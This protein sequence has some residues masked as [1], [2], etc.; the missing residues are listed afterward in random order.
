[1]DEETDG[2]GG[3]TLK[4]F[5]FAITRDV[6][7]SMR[8]SVEAESIEDAHDIGLERYRFALLGWEMDDF[9]GRPYIA[10]PDDYNILDESPKSAQ[11]MCPTATAWCSTRDLAHSGVR[12]GGSLVPSQEV[13]DAIEYCIDWVQESFFRCYRTD[14]AGG[15]SVVD[16]GVLYEKRMLGVRRIEEWFRCL[17]K[18]P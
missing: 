4:V 12:S 17:D 15:L 1:M 2:E 6:T 8:C 3:T 5:E 7:Q 11:P 9:C 10:D 16:A 14:L 18:Y 13:R